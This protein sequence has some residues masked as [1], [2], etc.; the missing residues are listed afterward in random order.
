MNGTAYLILCC[1]SYAAKIS[2]FFSVHCGFH[3]SL[4]GKKKL[5]P[6]NFLPE[7]SKYVSK[8]RQACLQCFCFPKLVLA[9]Q[10]HCLMFTLIT[11]FVSLF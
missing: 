2:I 11:R 6:S 1:V 4:V 9:Q 10:S 5:Y 7:K 8:N 3:S